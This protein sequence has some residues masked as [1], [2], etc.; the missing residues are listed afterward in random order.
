MS[1]AEEE[2]QQGSLVVVG[3][4][5]PNTGAPCQAVTLDSTQCLSQGACSLEVKLVRAL[6]EEYMRRESGFSQPQLHLQIVASWTAGAS[7]V[8][9]CAL[10]PSL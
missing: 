5:L 6:H 2:G 9:E 10:S 7:A 1:R 4:H 3:A 8:T